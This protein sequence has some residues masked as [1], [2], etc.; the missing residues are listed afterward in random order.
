LTNASEPTVPRDFWK[1]NMGATASDAVYSWV[2]VLKTFRAVRTVPAPTSR[3]VPIVGV[4]VH[5]GI[6]AA[7]ERIVPADPMAR[8][9]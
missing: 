2:V 4:A 5:A 6:P 9:A 1:I 7:T 8:R 3:E